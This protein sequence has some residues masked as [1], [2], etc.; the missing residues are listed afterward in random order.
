[1]KKGGGRKPKTNILDTDL[2][3]EGKL[4][5]KIITNVEDTK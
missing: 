1:L 3:V 5:D 4:D 2:H